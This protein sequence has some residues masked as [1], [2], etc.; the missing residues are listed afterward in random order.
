MRGKVVYYMDS[1]SS[2]GGELSALLYAWL[3]NCSLISWKAGNCQSTDIS[4]SLRFSG[5]WRELRKENRR[6]FCLLVPCHST[7][8][9]VCRGPQMET[10]E[11][12][13]GFWAVNLF[14]VVYLYSFFISCLWVFPGDPGRPSI[15]FSFPCHVYNAEGGAHWLTGNGESGD[16]K[17]QHC[18]ACI[19]GGVLSNGHAA[20]Q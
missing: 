3:D 16:G 13:L 2:I 12:C 1:V 10:L 15:S 18:D 19:L 9:R 6:L 20:G 17:R 4:H 14:F 7:S 5:R 11:D 8:I